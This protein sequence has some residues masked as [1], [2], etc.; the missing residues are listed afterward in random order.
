MAK[1][2]KISAFFLIRLIG[3]VVFIF[4]LFTI[5]LQDTINILKETNL[6]W[7]FLALLFQLILLLTKGV[8]WHI[9]NDGKN[10]SLRWLTS[11]HNFF[12]SYTI[13]V[14]TPGR[15]G[16]FVK[17]G[18]EENKE[19]KAGS[20]LRMI[21]ERGYDIG[22]FMV[23]AS[24]AIFATN[25]IELAQFIGVTGMLAGLI[26]V[27]ISFLLMKSV[28]ASKKIS[29]LISFLSFKKINLDFHI[30]EYAVHNIIL[31]F[32][33]S[34]IS[35]FCYFISSYFLALSLNIEG[36]LAV[37]S[38]VALAGLLNLIPITIMGLGTRE[39]VF[40]S[41]FKNLPKPTVLGFS[42]LMLLVAQIGGGLISLALK[43][44]F[45]LLIKFSSKD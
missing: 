5:N 26:I 21:T 38:A 15:L 23:I 13:G 12:E 33:L 25:P 1:K 41:I 19:K 29:K 9:L 2:K 31:I 11:M 3:I 16:E 20:I 36:F 7:F 17:A 34:L 27:I 44:I 40:F 28:R 32:T 39:L 4:I 14:F 37:S 42:G 30:Q 24:V 22:F 45:L 18:H 43:Y 10:N 6:N 35:N 8:R